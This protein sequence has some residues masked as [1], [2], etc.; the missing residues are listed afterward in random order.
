MERSEEEGKAVMENRKEGEKEEKEE[1][2]RGGG[3]GHLLIRN[4]EVFVYIKLKLRYGGRGGATHRWLSAGS[5]RDRC[6]YH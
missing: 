1:R 2:E 6:F 4:V 5:H 3:G